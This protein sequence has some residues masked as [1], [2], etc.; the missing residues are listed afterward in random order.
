MLKFSDKILWRIKDSRIHDLLAMEGVV[1]ETDLGMCWLAGGALRGLVD[2]QDVL[3][4]FDLFFSNQLRAA[5]TAVNLESNGFHVIFKCPKGELTTYLKI[6]EPDFNDLSPKLAGS[7]YIKVQ[8]ITKD[9]YI[10]SEHLL[11]TFDIN[12]GRFAYNG[13]HI[14]TDREAISDVRK[15]ELTLN[16][17]THPNATFKRL[18]KYREK[19]FKLP[20]ST[21]D[22]F[23][24]SVY[25]MG[26]NEDSLQR[27]FYVD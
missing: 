4:D 18:L 21:I 6:T 1:G 19:R 26:R 23:V 9:F 11:A 7:Q 20:N 13:T 2:K 17:V 27:Q 25:N 5:E 12:A 8:L 3:C 10:H 22:F 24:E 15:K 14:Y 16:T